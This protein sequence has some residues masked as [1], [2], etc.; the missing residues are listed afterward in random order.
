MVMKKT[1]II[2]L[3]IAVACGG[4]YTGLVLYMR[5]FTK[6]KVM[7]TSDDFS[8]FDCV[9]VLGAGV[10]DDGTPSLMLADRL[11]TGV[12]IYKNGTVSK[13]IMSGDHGTDNY[14]EVNVMKSYA[15]NRGVLSEDIFMDHAGFSTYE[16]IYRARDIFEAKKIV[17]VTQSYHLYRALYIAEKLGVDAVGVSAD[18]V[19]YGGQTYRNFRELAAYGKDFLYCLFGAKP[20]YLGD[21]VPVSGDG[22]V[23]NDKTR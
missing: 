3:I 20:T 12:E 16:S 11:N 21:S 1:I 18:T 13:L 19:S 4:L 10:R 17:I 23:T 14:D 9:L 22:N 8:G 5:S 7:S 15:V 6:G 2:L